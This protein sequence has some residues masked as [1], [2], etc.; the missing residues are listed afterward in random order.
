VRKPGGRRPLGRSR[1]RCEDNVKT[2]FGW[3]GV[4][5][6]NL[7][8]NRDKWQTVVNTVMNLQVP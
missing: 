6:I 1:H 5:W 7:V 4:D 3:E 8:S 2:N